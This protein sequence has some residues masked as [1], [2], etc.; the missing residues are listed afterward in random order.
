M[1]DHHN[2]FVEKVTPKRRGRPIRQN[3][4]SINNRLVAIK[5]ST[6][7]TSKRGKK[8]SL[9]TQSIQMSSSMPDLNNTMNTSE[10]F[11]HRYGTRN[12]FRK[13][14]SILAV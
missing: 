11:T 9:I 1:H 10:M 5:K 13:K 4:P 3:T 8:N 2:Q 12:N 7:T 6:T 14:N